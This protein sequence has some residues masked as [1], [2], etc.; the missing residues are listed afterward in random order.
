M[1]LT[2]D[3]SAQQTSPTP[4][5]QA[6]EVPPSGKK[7]KKE[8]LTFHLKIYSPYKTYF[9]GP[10]RSISAANDKGPFDILPK[11]HNFLTLLNAGDLEV[12]TATEKETIKI[13]RGIMHV[14]ADDVTVF[15]D[16]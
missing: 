8:D 4:V 5:A 1:E 14:K 16:I 2:D 7:L 11:H 15:L 12:R 6:A 13:S 3:T 9:D 10:A